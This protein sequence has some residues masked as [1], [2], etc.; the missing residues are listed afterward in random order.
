MAAMCL[1]N[2]M[3]TRYPVLQNHDMD[4]T[5]DQGNK[6]AGAWRNDSVLHDVA[7]AGRG[8]MAN[9]EGKRVCALI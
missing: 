6:L 5:D 9:W 1:H 2:L 7:E 8:Y 4:H 3:R